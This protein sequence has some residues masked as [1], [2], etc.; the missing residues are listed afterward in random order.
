M[1]NLNPNIRLTKLYKSTIG[2]SKPE[3]DTE[4]IVSIPTNTFNE[5]EASGD[6]LDIIQDNF[7]Y[8]FLKPVIKHIED[9]R[10]DV[11]DIHSY[12]STAFGLDP[13]QAASVGAQGPQGATGPIGV[14]GNTG[15]TGAA[16]AQGAA[17]M[18]AK[19]PKGFTGNQTV[20]VDGKFNTVTLFY[21]N[22]ILVNIK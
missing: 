2:I 5:I 7:K 11:E 10:L 13:N 14:K 20:I 16:G 15:A 18:D 1:A 12:L 21:D 4:G 8:E 9:L 17:G 3:K 22:G 19:L 6:I